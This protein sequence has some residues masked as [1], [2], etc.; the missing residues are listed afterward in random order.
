MPILGKHGG[1]TSWSFDQSLGVEF[2]AYW[3][4]PGRAGGLGPTFARRDTTTVFRPP[5]NFWLSLPKADMS[6]LSHS[7]QAPPLASRGD[8]HAKGNNCKHRP[9][10][11]KKNSRSYH[12]AA[13][14]RA[15]GGAVQNIGEAS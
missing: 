9:T 3:Q 11:M 15:Y 8:L 6:D 1:S 14:N 5:K 13:G 2:G 10:A 4:A 7:N 12:Q